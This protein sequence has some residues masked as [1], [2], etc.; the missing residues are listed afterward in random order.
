MKLSASIW[1]CWP[2]NLLIELTI[3]S[4]VLGNVLATCHEVVGEVTDNAQDACQQTLH[5]LVLEE[6]I[7][8]P[9]LGENAA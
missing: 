9:E 2:F 4:E 8:S 5:G 6:H 1:A 3:L 7:A